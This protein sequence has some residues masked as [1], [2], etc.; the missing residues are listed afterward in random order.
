[1]RVC[2]FNRDFRRWTARLWLRLALSPLRRLAL[3]LDDRSGRAQR[4][5]PRDWWA[6]RR[7]APGP[8]PGMRT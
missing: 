4:L 2:P 6:E 1:M 8:R 5:R 7:R 3:W